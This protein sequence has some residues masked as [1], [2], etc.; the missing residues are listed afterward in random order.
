MAYRVKF[1]PR[2]LRE[3][4]GAHEWHELQSAGLGEEFV[5]SNE[6][7]L[8]RLA[9]APF[10]CA[11]ISLRDVLCRRDDLIHILAVIHH[12]RNPSR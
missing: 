2:A 11:E 3:I 8:K 12:A 7:Q 5:A 10:P 1:S 4:G 9:R 6:F